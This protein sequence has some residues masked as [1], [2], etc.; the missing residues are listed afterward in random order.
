MLVQEGKFQ[1][2]ATIV[3][4]RVLVKRNIVNAMKSLDYAAYVVAILHQEILVMDIA[5]H[6]AIL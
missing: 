5:I 1:I 2:F 3:A 6:V 4:H